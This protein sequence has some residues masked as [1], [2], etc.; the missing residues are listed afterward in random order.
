MNK[1][2]ERVILNTLLR[3]GDF[4]GEIIDIEQ[5]SG[6]C[7]VKLDC[8]TTPVSGVLYFDEPPEI[9]NSQLWQF[10]WPDPHPIKIGR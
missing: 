8:Q 1:I 2:G 3:Q 9:V 4:P 10:C 6:L 7:L 5:F